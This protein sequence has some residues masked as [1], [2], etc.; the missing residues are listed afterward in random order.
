MLGH[1]PTT[2][3]FATFLVLTLP[4]GYPT[5]TLKIRINVGGCNNLTFHAIRG[6]FY[7]YLF[8]YIVDGLAEMRSVILKTFLSCHVDSA[9]LV[10]KTE[11]AVNDVNKRSDFVV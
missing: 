6:T 9:T 2:D 11:V 8:M 7:T 10:S 3:S 4:Y 1:R 5:D